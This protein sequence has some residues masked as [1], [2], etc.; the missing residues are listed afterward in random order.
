MLS[1][2]EEV[3]IR[4]GGN[5]FAASTFAVAEEPPEVS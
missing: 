2:K 3:E 4:R 5:H 1:V